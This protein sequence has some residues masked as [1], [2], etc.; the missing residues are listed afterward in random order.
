MISPPKSSPSFTYLQHTITSGANWV[1]LTPGVYYLGM[2]AI[3]CLALQM[4]DTNGSVWV[5]SGIVK[6]AVG[7]NS[8]G[9]FITDGA[10]VRINAISADRSA[11]MIIQS[12]S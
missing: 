7:N 10:N 2:D 6:T 5:E 11:T 1:P 9:M 8:M 3:T 4:Y 12:W